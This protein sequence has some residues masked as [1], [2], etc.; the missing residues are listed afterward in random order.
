[1]KLKEALKKYNFLKK[2]DLSDNIVVTLANSLEQIKKGS[3]E[4]YM[5]PLAKCCDPV[6]TLIDWDVIFEDNT[7]KMNSTLL[8]LERSNRSKF[9]SRS[10][11]VPWAQR[12][13]S[14]RDSFS[15]QDESHKP[16]Y[17]RLIGES[18]LSPA[19]LE[20]AVE[21]IKIQSS[22]GLPFLCSKGRAKPT[23]L[24]DL[25]KYLDRRD[26]CTLLTRTQEGKKTRNVWGYPFAD[27]LHE[28]KFYYPLLNQQKQKKYRAALVSPDTVSECITELILKARSSNRFIYSVDFSAFDASVKFQ[29]IIAAFEY[30][31]SC[32]APMFG[33]FIT[34]ICERFYTIGIVTPLA[35]FR[36]KHGVPSGSTFTNEIDSI[37]QIMIALVNDFIREDE[38][39]VQGD[40]G[41]YIMLLDHLQEFKDSFTYTGLLL[42]EGKSFISKDFAVYCQNLFHIDYIKDDLIGGIYPTYRAINRI[43]FQER[44]VNFKKQGISGKDYYAIRCY[45]I[46][47][48][49]KHH[50]LFE[51]LVRFILAREEYTLEM[52][53][54]GLA[55]YCVSV[56]LDQDSPT[57][58]RQQHGSNVRGIKNFESFK[59]VQKIV[60]EPGYVRKSKP[61]HESEQ[62]SS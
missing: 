17:K 35:V 8:D 5:T 9:G 14:L 56:G 53:D 44:F 52:S 13:D 38:C 25:D 2:L 34:E 23:L 58:P 33:Q 55:A 15:N 39:Q 48:N 19:T 49:C 29:Y 36:G 30:I 22:A 62:P 1:M 20:E 45:S 57:N 27:A 46:L 42:N 24:S 43:L 11:Q 4:V 16:R 61:D 51:E 26:P 7:A 18:R 60:N 6:L 41:V 54:E 28:M 12:V 47:E 21:R 40:D 31:K 59:L 10:E 3:S 50:P 32:F 37:V